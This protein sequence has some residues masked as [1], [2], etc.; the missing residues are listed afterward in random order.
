MPK[1]VHFNMM[2]WKPLDG[3]WHLS[4]G[5]HFR[6]EFYNCQPIQEY[7]KELN[8]EN[9]CFYKMIIEKIT[10]EEYENASNKMQR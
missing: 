5:G 10:R 4:E 9:P 7:F 3:K 1:T 8:K 2:S 6:Q